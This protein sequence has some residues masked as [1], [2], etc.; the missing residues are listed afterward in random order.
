MVLEGLT[1]RRTFFILA[2]M[3][4]IRE[5]LQKLLSDENL[6]VKVP[7]VAIFDEHQERYFVDSNGRKCDEADSVDEVVRNFDRE[8]L[9]EIA[10]SCNERDESGSLSPLVFGHTIPGE[11]DETK[12]P[13]PK[14]Y[15][16]GYGVRYDKSLGRN[17][18]TTNFY[19][20]KDHFEAAKT[21]PRISVELWPKHKVVDPIALIRRTPRRDLPQ[22][23]YSREGDEVL[24]YSMESEMPKRYEMDDIDPVDTPSEMDAPGD[25]ASQAEA[26]VRH[27]MKFP[28]FKEMVDR[29]SA[30]PMSAE[31]PPGPNP[32]DM[33]SDMVQNSAAASATN[34]TLPV[35]MPR[36]DSDVEQN[37]RLVRSNNA[38]RQ[39]AEMQARL[40]KMDAE[41]RAAEGARYVTQL[42]SEGYELDATRESEHFARLDESAREEH[43][44]YVRKFHKH[45]VI[46]NRV[47]IL[48]EGSA[49]PQ[50][51]ARDS[52]E[53]SDKEFAEAMHYVREGT[54]PDFDTALAKVRS[55][56]KLK[57]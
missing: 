7:D 9:Q 26:F 30:P 21:F 45:N 34:G 50:R 28:G 55:N 12:Q 41:K 16:L 20:R 42:L 53:P 8:E 25:E 52:S 22:W 18:L 27:C 51:N 54:I 10:D 17:V 29:Y 23:I 38:A 33:P 47:P 43:A 35:G 49:A 5:R 24:R 32:T 2:L 48:G 57:K 6:Y 15:A 31:E 4:A 13:P 3:S 56:G 11:K 39:L 46:G 14:G 36:K 19:V 44:D 37:A 40:D 1:H